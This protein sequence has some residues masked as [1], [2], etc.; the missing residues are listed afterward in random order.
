MLSSHT[1]KNL[2]VVR[3]ITNCLSK[4]LGID[5]GNPAHVGSV[6]RVVSMLFSFVVITATVGGGSIT[7]GFFTKAFSPGLVG[8][9]KKA[10]DLSKN[11]NCVYL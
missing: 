11:H 9:R 10:L 5:L 8:I 7:L 4:P 3:S 6:R 1:R 2:A